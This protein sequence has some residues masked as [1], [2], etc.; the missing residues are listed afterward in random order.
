MKHP[1]L[2]SRQKSKCAL[3]FGEADKALADGADEE[4]WMLDVALRVYKALVE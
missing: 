2:N 3:I 1:T 4:L